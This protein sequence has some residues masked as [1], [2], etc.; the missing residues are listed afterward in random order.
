MHFVDS[1]LMEQTTQE[2][3]FDLAGFSYCTYQE[4]GLITNVTHCAI[5]HAED[6]GG[7][8]NSTDDEICRS[9]SI[10][11]NTLQVTI[12]QPSYRFIQPS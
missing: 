12:Q 4:T 11:M 8:Y 9:T 3:Y 7:N 1:A 6:L 10:M 5:F 2:Q